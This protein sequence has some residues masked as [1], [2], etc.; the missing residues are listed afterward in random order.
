MIVP[1]KVYKYMGPG[2]SVVRKIMTDEIRINNWADTPVGT[3]VT[4]VEIVKCWQDKE[5]NSCF[6]KIIFD[7]INMCTNYGCVYTYVSLDELQDS[8]R[9]LPDWW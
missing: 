8:K 4:V 1:G 9:N 5:A 6:A 7:N 2:K 3:K